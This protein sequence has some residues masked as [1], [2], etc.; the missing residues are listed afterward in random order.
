MGN[1]RKAGKGQVGPGNGKKAKADN[2][3]IGKY[4][5]GGFPIDPKMKG[6]MVTCARGKESQAGKEACDLLSEYA[7]KL[8]G[9]GSNEEVDEDENESIEDAIAREVAQAKKTKGGRQFLPLSTGTDCVIF[10]RAMEIEPSSLCH[11]VLSELQKSGTKRTRYCQRFIPV[12]ETSYA[13]MDDIKVMMERVLKPYFHAEDQQPTTFKVL[14]KVRHNDKV[15]REVLVKT[16]ASAAG[17]NQKHAVSLNDPTF[18]ILAEVIKSICF[19]SVVKDYDRLKKYNIQTIFM[20]SQGVK[21]DAKPDMN[22]SKSIKKAEANVNA[23]NEI[24]IE[25]AKDVE[26]KDEVANAVD[27]NN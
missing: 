4:L 3:K 6:V 7:E 12:E 27:Q 24:E 10:I 8:Y 14:P 18:V 13:N 23:D 16:L 21:L 17:R 26:K 9:S 22:E 20:D 19:L 11:Y 2:H 1:K 25:P 15:D 5:P